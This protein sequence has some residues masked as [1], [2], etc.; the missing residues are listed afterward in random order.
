MKL[1]RRFMEIQY[2]IEEME[3]AVETTMIEDMNQ[4]ELACVCIHYPKRWEREGKAT[5][6]C[7]RICSKASGREGWKGQSRLQPSSALSLGT[8]GQSSP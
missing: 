4:E 5:S 3:H 1:K 2:D 6:C 7:F 8:T